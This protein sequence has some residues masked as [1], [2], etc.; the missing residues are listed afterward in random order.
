MPGE[1]SRFFSGSAVWAL[2]G[3]VGLGGAALAGAQTR[4]SGSRTARPLITQ[5]IDSRQVVVLKGNVRQDL[6]PARDL[7]PVEDGLPLRLYLVLRR[8]PEQQAELDN[9]L[10][11]QQQPSAAEYHQ[12]LTPQQFGERFGAAERDIA[13]ITNWLAGQGL[14][15]HSVLNNAS[16]IDFSATAGQVRTT[17]HT[18]LHYYSIRGGRYPA[19]TQEPMIPAALEPVVAG[20]AGLVKIPH[21]ANHTVPRQASYDAATHRW[22]E[23][24]VAGETRPWPAYSD[25]SGNYNLTP[26]DSYTI[27]NVNK[28]FRAGNLAASANVAVIEESDI[29]YGTV[30]GT[31]N[32]ASGGD[33]AT[34][35]SLFGVPG[36]LNM[37]V[38]HGYGTVTCNAPGIDP[39]G[40][41]E[42]VEAALD[43]E[44]ANA[45]APAANLIFMSCDQ[46]PDNGIFSSMAALIDNNLADS[47]SLSYGE[48]ELNASSSDYTLL[49]TLYA[50]ADAQGQSFFV[51]S[52]DSGS[53]V[54]DQKSSY[55]IGT[56]GIN[57]NAFGSPN[58]TVAGGTDFQDAYDNAEGGAPL[59]T[60]WGATN[61]A[62]YG[63]AL[64][65][66]PETAW[67][68]SCANSLLA[69]YNGYAGADYCATG[70]QIYV[71]GGSGGF[72]THYAVPA[73]Q[74]GILGY[75][76]SQR[77]QPDVSG[78]A[79]DG[80]SGHLLVFCD[81]SQSASDCS[82]PSNFG[83]AGGTS[84]VAPYFA[85]MA[86]L[87]VNSTGSRQGLLNP[88]LYALAK[89]QF[90]GSA[91]S[92]ACYANGQTSNIGVTTGLPAANCIFNDVTTSNNDVPCLLE[93]TDCYVNG[94][95]FFGILSTNANSLAVAYASTP[96]YDE[97]TGIGTINVY[98]LISNWNTAFSS[99][100]VLGAQPAAISTSQSTTLTATVTSGTPVGYVDT[101]PALS[102]T[103]NFSA[104]G[105]SSPIGTCTLGAIS[106]G[107]GSCSVTVS[108][109]A[110]NTG[111]NL[112]TATF[113][114]S[115]TYP[116]S[117]SNNETVTVTVGGLSSSAKYLG[118]DTTNQ[119]N[120][121]G[122]YGADGYLIAN[123]TSN[124]P[125]YTSVSLSGNNSYTWTTST[126]DPR[127]LQTAPSGRIASAYYA[128]GNFKINVNISDGGTH[129]VALYL[130]DWD[131]T[132]RA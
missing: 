74:T 89:A 61:S 62:T 37:H 125:A 101:P 28:V 116:A 108:G 109:A 63:D 130:L 80:L 22:H 114:G 26:Q 44:W 117:T 107:S 87:L 8:S 31:T 118:Y 34:F 11:R 84:F 119:G 103:V 120:W 45:L 88:A 106:Q 10:A 53:D 111:A 43:A 104:A 1:S 25:G 94:F 56:S 75:T 7:G 99:T 73:Y 64:S 23:A 91:T 18:P 72:S 16:I 41:G 69:H 19:N 102:G 65:Y 58:V 82:S 35:R 79:S 50:Q 42:E 40:N 59:S 49:D 46:S 131:S 13:K 38:Y 112:I 123:K 77:A 24:A 9:L 52:G 92:T 126:T 121:M 12:W 36:T 113:S 98:N 33:V 27:Y 20:I 47:M 60:Y 132:A 21:V 76:G 129:R 66:V 85:G 2:V 128:G 105:I 57:V 5:Q 6:T 96:G 3:L 15:V 48:S 4:A 110:L 29:E 122:Q 86:G 90:T 39:D 51:S 55:G 17:F 127:A 95:N 70:S 71:V 78:F 93:T 30:N 83:T 97:V 81:S 124:A 100:T 115:G 32:A 14:E 54:A 68:S 67:N